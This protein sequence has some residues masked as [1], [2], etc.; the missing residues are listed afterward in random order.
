MDN[1]F[2]RMIKKVVGGIKVTEETLAVDIIK[3]V[4]AA[5]EFISHDQTL[6]LFKTEMTQ[7]KLINRASREDYFAGKGKDLTERAYEEAESIYQAHKPVPLP[8]NVLSEIRSIV[9][10]AE[11]H[12]GLDKSTS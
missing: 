1:E 4:G 6:Q 3:Q 9:N 8:D 10:E 2:A 11:D 5:G 12:F 7:S